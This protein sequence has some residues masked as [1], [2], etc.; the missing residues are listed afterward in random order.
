MARTS[1]PDGKRSYSQVHCGCE[2]AGLVSYIG[3]AEGRMLRML[4]LHLA[5]RP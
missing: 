5:S 4:S 1:V 3:K 2:A